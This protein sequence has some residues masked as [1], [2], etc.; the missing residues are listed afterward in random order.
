MGS[1]VEKDGVRG[2]K[3][4]GQRSKKRGSEVEK[5]GVRGQKSRECGRLG[6]A[7]VPEERWGQRLLLRERE[8]ER[9]RGLTEGGG[10][11]NYHHG[12]NTGTVS[13]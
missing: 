11:V 1:E 5:D 9:E 8:G 12:K 6:Q 3:R 7:S 10:V 13:G 4:W 2:R